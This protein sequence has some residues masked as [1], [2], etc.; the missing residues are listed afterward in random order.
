MEA[1]PYLPAYEPGTPKRHGTDRGAAFYLNALRFAQGH[2]ME[3]KPAQAILQLNKAFSADL[4]EDDPILETWPWP[5]SALE[6]ILERIR[7]RQ[8]RLPR[9]PGSTFSAP[10]DTYERAAKGSTALSAHGNVSTSPDACWRRRG[11]FPW[12]AGRSR[13]KGFS[14]HPEEMARKSIAGW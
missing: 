5:Y 7:G 9:K 4:S 13:G 10:G 11:D 3:G 8:S 6:W 14:F 2:W 1:C 12:M